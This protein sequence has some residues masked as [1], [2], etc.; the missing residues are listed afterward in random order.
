MELGKHHR[1]VVNLVT[2][3]LHNFDSS[4]PNSCMM[5]GITGNLKHQMEIMLIS[6]G[7]I[8]D[9][10]VPVMIAYGQDN[11]LE[12]LRQCCG[13]QNLTFQSLV[14]LADPYIFT[15]YQ[16]NAVQELQKGCSGSKPP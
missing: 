13:S 14:Y 7:V 16:V 2:R 4:V 15:L 9:K 10:F 12:S 1:I 8:W 11:Y 3:T 6:L 5:S